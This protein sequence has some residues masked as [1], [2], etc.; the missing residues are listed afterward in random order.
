MANRS[1][2]AAGV[3]AGLACAA[4]LLVLLAGCGSSSAVSSSDGGGSGTGG[5]SGGGGSTAGDG[6]SLYLNVMPPGSNGNS[7]GG[8]G[9][10]VPG[11]PVLKYPAN[12]DDQLSLY[13]DLSYA[14][15]GLLTAPC[16]PPTDI[17]QHQQASNLACNYYK[18]EGLKPDTVAS[19]ETLTLPNG[20]QVTITRDNWGV[21]FIDAPNRADAEYGV[22]YANAE[23]RLWLDD[24]L[25][26]VGRG[27]VT[28][29]LGVAPG[30]TRVIVRYGFM[31]SPNIPVA[32]RLCQTLGLKADFDDITYYVG[33]ETLIPKQK[34]SMWWPW[35]RHLFVFLTRNAMRNTAFYHLPPEDVV[36]LGFQVEI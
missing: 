10:P 19:T 32:L 16:T 30:I 9:A 7:A 22:G 35:R 34:V 17:S 25:R 12:F 5:T 26:H 2:G 6:N 4:F 8:L 1:T 36:E 18:H 28:Q 14:K 33:R 29:Y 20:D 3:R 13:G 31:Q 11:V 27:M 24:V 21:P 23:D 15:Q